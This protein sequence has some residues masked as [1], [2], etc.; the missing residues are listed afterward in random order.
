MGS[1]SCI[2]YG[3]G[4]IINCGV[5]LLHHMLMTGFLYVFAYAYNSKFK[6]NNSKLNSNGKRYDVCPCHV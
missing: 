4:T 3:S 5:E 1:I 6:K 2:Y